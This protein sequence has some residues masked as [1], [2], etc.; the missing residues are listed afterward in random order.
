MNRQ[1]LLVEPNYKNK[2]PPMGL[3]KISTYHKL[4]EDDVRFYK[5]SFEDFVLDEIYSELLEKLYANDSSVSWCERRNLIIR[6]IKVGKKDD[7]EELLSYSNTLFIGE[8]FL[9]YHDY[10][11]KKKYLNK[12]KWDRIYFTTLFTFHWKITIETIN[13]FKQ[14]CKNPDQVF[15]GGIAS[16]LVPKEFEN[17]TGIKPIV[18]LLDKPK[19]LLDDNDI[20]IDTLPLD[21]SIL[22]EIDYEYPESDGYY[23][24]MTRGCVNRCSFCA[25]PKLEPEYINYIGIKNQIDETDKQFGVRRHLLL[26]DNNV[27]ASNRFD[28][29]IDEIKECGFVKGATCKYPNEY[30]LSIKGLK[31]G[32]NDRGYIRNIIKQYNLLMTKSSKDNK[33]E[34]YNILSEN[35][36]LCYDARKE[37]ILKLDTYFSPLFEKVYSHNK[38]WRYVDFNQGIDARL[39]TEYKIKRLSEI[40]IKPLRIAFDN[41]SY[42]E[43]Y[44]KAV[45]LAAK[46][47]IDH[48]SNYLLYNYND[49]P[50]ELY[51][52]IEM[53]VLLAEELGVH[54]YSFPMKYHPIQDP[55]YFRTRNYLGKHWNRKFIRSVQAILNSTKGKIGCGKSYFYEAF[56]KNEKEFFKLMYMPEALIIYRFYYKEN[57]TT[58]KWWSEFCSLSDEQQAEAKRLIENYDFK[59]IEKLTS[60]K[61]IQHILNYYTMNTSTIPN[62]YTKK[63]MPK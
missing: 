23:G 24:Y 1:I 19:M 41:W 61:Q 16:S 56:G 18:G 22:Y 5:G 25:V 63:K 37:D 50:I 30:E 3:M 31:S 60:D 4:L 2:Y 33:H 48:L 59:D 58:D 32:Y 35:H 52:R 36:L 8:N 57:G 40:P 38:T 34:I 43:I 39:V 12:K 44:E 49:K 47:G 27:L 14:L 46:Y 20:I 54:I 15:V 45:R 6:Y 55:E 21:Y 29:I 17:E 26:L 53:N 62:G 13:Q 51:Y 42:K 28:D 7:L 11:K 10:Y 9:Y